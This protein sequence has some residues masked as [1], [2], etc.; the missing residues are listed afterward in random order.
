MRR[1]YTICLVIGTVVLGA[2]YYRNHAT[3]KEVVYTGRALTFN[4]AVKKAM[5][6]TRRVQLGIKILYYD[7][8][9]QYL[10]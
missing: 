9:Q 10:K 4:P 2:I 5:D 3:N 6:S 7:E 1:L 8:V